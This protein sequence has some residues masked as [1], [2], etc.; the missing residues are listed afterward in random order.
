MT[1]RHS[2]S[3]LTGDALFCQRPLAGLIVQAGRDYLLAVKDNQ[4]DLMEAM[5]AAFDRADLSAPDARTVEK[6]GRWWTPAGCG[7]IATRATTCASS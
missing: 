2:V 3:L 1:A 4:P 5:H 6:K 7:P